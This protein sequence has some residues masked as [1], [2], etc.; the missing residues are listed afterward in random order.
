LAEGRIASGLIPVER[1]RYRRRPNRWPAV[2][3]PGGRLAAGLL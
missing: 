2:I 1:R 3:A